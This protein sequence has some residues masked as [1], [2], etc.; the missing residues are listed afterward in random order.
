MVSRPSMQLLWNR[1]KAAIDYINEQ[2]WVCSDKTV[3]NKKKMGI[4]YG[5]RIPMAN[6]D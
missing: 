2:S 6:L 3:Y 1:I 4:R 5:K